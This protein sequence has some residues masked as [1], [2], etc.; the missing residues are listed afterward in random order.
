MLQ[1]LQLEPS[2][3]RILVW[4]GL[5]SHE[6]VTGIVNAAEEQWTTAVP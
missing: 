2:Q 4:V 3:Q 5:H 6:F 1:A